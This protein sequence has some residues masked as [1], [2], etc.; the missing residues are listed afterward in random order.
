M[1]IAFSEVKNY[2]GAPAETIQQRGKPAWHP[3]AAGHDVLSDDIGKRRIRM[4]IRNDCR[5][6]L[7]SEDNEEVGRLAQGFRNADIQPARIPT[8]RRI[9]QVTRVI[10]L[11]PLGEADRSKRQ[12][13]AAGSGHA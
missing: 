11:N 13:A 12:Q 9:T 6:A 5:P 2:F 1:Q 8:G 10:E 4:E 7:L 3:L